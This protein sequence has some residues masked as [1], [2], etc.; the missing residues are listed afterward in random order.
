MY[1]NEL[2]LKTREAFEAEDAER[3][4]KEEEEEKFDLTAYLAKAK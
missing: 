1:Q 4:K 3:R 2:N